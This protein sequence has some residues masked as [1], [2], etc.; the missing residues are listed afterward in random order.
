MPQW[1]F[2]FDTRRAPKHHFQNFSS[3]RF[4]VNWDIVQLNSTFDVEC[5]GEDRII[6]GKCYKTDDVIDEPEGFLLSIGILDQTQFFFIIGLIFVILLVLKANISR[7]RKGKTVSLSKFEL[8]S[9][10]ERNDA[11]PTTNF[12][13][14]TYTPTYNTEYNLPVY[15]PSI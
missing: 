13:E 5:E 8:E 12:N 11:F 3:G 9:D 4:K 1:L 10:L 6:D 15:I 7:R 14:P 2:L